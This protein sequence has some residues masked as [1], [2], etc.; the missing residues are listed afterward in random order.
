MNRDLLT[1]MLEAMKRLSFEPVRL[2]IGDQAYAKIERYQATRM[3]AKAADEFMR[4]HFIKAERLP[5]DWRETVRLT[6]P[7]T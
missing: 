7:L 6:L 4:A 5:P 2:T 1:L 3:G